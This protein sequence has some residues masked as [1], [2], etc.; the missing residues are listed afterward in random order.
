MVNANTIKSFDMESIEDYFEYIIS[1]KYNGQHKQ[2]MELF[3]KLSTGIDGQRSEFFKYVEEY[4][5][6]IDVEELQMYF[7]IKLY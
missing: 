3:R 7:G 1:S 6:H 2:T 4:W 5:N